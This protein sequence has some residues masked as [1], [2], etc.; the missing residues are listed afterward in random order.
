MGWFTNLGCGGGGDLVSSSHGQMDTD[1]GASICLLVAAVVGSTV[2]HGQTEQL[3]LLSECTS[4]AFAA[5]LERQTGFRKSASMEHGW[6]FGGGSKYK[7]LQQ[8]SSSR[9]EQ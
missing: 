7:N 9:V 4:S 8:F 5:S 1:T 2:S 6:R 3:A